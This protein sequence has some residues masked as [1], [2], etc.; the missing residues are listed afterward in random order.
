MRTDKAIAHLANAYLV[1]E[2]IRAESNNLDI[3]IAASM[4]LVNIS[5]AQ[6]KAFE[7]KAILESE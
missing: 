4:A 5:E 6:Q 7:I 3:Q 1:I 2:G